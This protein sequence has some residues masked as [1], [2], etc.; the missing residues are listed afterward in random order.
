MTG[1]GIGQALLTGRLAAESILARRAPDQPDIATA[2]YERAVAPPSDRRP[3]HV[4]AARSRPVDVVGRAWRDARRGVERRVGSP[5]LRTVDVRGRTAGDPA[6]ARSVAPADAP[7]ARRVSVGLSVRTVAAMRRWRPHVDVA[8]RHLDAVGVDVARLTRALGRSRRSCPLSAGLRR[9]HAARASLRPRRPEYP[10]LAAAGL[11]HREPLGD[12]RGRPARDRHR[13]RRTAARHRRLHHRRIGGSIGH[14]VKATG[15]PGDVVS[16][17]G[18][19]AQVR[20]RREFD[21]IA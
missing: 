21:A 12:R 2:A 9:R 18:R 19:S 3:S 15:A 10:T 20:G 1:E 7:A 14:A 13:R 17:R 8:D 16:D 4:G 11:D 5:Q 6:H